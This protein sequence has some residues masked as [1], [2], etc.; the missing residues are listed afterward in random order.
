[1]TR[2]AEGRRRSGVWL[3]DE[4]WDWLY[5]RSADGGL[6]TSD[7]IEGLVLLAIDREEHGVPPLRPVDKLLEHR[8]DLLTE[9]RW[10]VA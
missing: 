1:M 10:P 8:P 9:W 6:Q 2:D 7:L 4:C 3:P 5:D